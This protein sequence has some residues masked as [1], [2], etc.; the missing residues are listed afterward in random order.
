[1]SMKRTRRPV[2]CIWARWSR[3]HSPPRCRP[4]TNHCA[5]NSVPWLPSRRPTRCWMKRNASSKT[6][7]HCCQKTPASSQTN[8]V[9]KPFIALTCVLFMAKGVLADPY[10]AAIQQAK[11]VSAQ[12]TAANQRLMDNPPPAAPPQNNPPP[13]DPALQATLQNIGS[14]RTDFAAI[15]NADATSSLTVQKQ[16]LTNDL[17]IAAQGAKPQPASI[18]KLADDLTTAIAGK[19]KLRAPQQK[20]AQFVHAIFNSAHLP[21]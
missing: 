20:L 16:L 4:E 8:E 13:A 2:C 5:A 7:F 3:K 14:L 6:T 10:S 11:R 18:S 12:E 9:M 21:D 17:A 19:E 15:G 1:M